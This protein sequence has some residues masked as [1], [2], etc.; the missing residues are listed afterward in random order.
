MSRIKQ[1]KKVSIIISTYKNIDYLDVVIDSINRQTYKNFEV[2]VA[3]DNNRVEMKEYLKK[4][5][6]NYEVII[7]HVSQEDRGFRKNKILNKAI[8]ISESE[9]LIFIDEDCVLHRNFVNEYIKNIN[10]NTCLFGR[11]VMLGEKLTEKIIKHKKNINIFNIY[12]SDSRRNEEGIYIPFIRHRKKGKGIVGSNF[13]INK[14]IL[15]EINGF[16][17]RYEEACIGEDVDVEMRLKK[18][19]TKFISLKN[20]AIQYHLWHKRSDRTEGYDKNLKILESN[21]EMIGYKCKYGLKNLEL[22]LDKEK[23]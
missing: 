21:K 18:Y 16:D 17:E 10:E 2:I 1:D 11:R 20:R 5:I 3:E 15:I 13:G 8:N 6:D 9:Y 12:F 14:N 22:I 23:I 4:A 7:K 19:G